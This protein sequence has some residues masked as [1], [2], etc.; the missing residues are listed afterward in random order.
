MF[1][2]GAVHERSS[3][4]CHWEPTTLWDDLSP[5]QPTQNL[6]LLKRRKR[7]KKRRRL[8]EEKLVSSGVFWGALGSTLFF[9]GM[10]KGGKK[11]IDKSK[12][13]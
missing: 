2:L 11:T 4:K 8:G 10:K 13:D 7:R 12:M 1:V 3:L 6:K 9:K 5:F